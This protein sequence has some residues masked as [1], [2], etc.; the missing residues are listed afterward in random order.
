MSLRTMHENRKNSSESRTSKPEPVILPEDLLKQA[1]EALTALKS[2]QAQRI[3]AEQRADSEAEKNRTLQRLLTE[4]S[5]TS[6]SEMPTK[7]SEMLKKQDRKLSNEQE[8]NRQ[9]RKQLKD[10]EEAVRASE[11]ASARQ[12]ALLE[13]ENYDLRRKIDFERFDKIAYLQ[14]IESREQELKKG[15]KALKID[16]ANFNRHV[17]DKAQEIE[18]KAVS[19]YETQK[20]RC[21]AEKT[22]LT[23]QQKAVETER[24]LWLQ[25]EKEKID[26]EVARQV[27]KHKAELDEQANEKQEKLQQNYQITK[28]RL[29][30]KFTT[31]NGLTVTVGLI[32]G[33]VAIISGFLAFTHGLLPF[34]IKDTKAIGKWI[35]EDWHEI[36]D[37]FAFPQAL[38]PI[39]QLAL[40]LIFLIVVGIWTAL[41]FEERKW[42]VFADE[43]SIMV[44]GFGVGMSTIFGKQISESGTNTV[45]L[46]IALYLLYVLVRWLCEIGAIEAVYDGIIGLTKKIADHF[47]NQNMNQNIGDIIVLGVIIVAVIM[48][49]HWLKN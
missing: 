21:E 11:K 20:A 29:E 8:Q 10:A 15:E 46:P 37:N 18:Q 47:G 36:F 23:E 22:R 3:Q 41:D 4:L 32:S 6:D 5:E 25:T 35:A 49:S 28:L 33:I 27:T 19:E 34:L 40:P 38:S 16:R 9:L 31:I 45:M 17:Q 24:Q 12:M 7:L 30:A 26:T 48:V 14:D 44:V 43:I 2:E 42:V 1:E 13:T 39:L